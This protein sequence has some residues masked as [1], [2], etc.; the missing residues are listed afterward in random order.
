MRRV[1]TL[2]DD[3]VALIA[4]GEVIER[5]AS[6]VKELIENSLDADAT[7]INIEIVN[8]G[9]DSIIVSDD[10]HG[11]LVEDCPLCIQRHTTSKIEKKSDIETIR[12]YGFR[13]E[14]LSSI[15][16]VAELNIITRAEE[17]ELGCSLSSR[18]GEPPSIRRVSR[19]R[20][21]TVEVRD[22][23]ATVPARRKHLGTPK[24]EAQRIAETVMR[25]AAIREDVGLTLVRDGQT[26]IDCPPKQT[27]L[28]RVVSLWGPAV[29]KMMTEVHHVDHIVGITISGYVV[30]PPLARGNRSREY[31]SVLKR[32]IEDER[33]SRA[34]ETAYETLL[35][36]GQYPMFM[37]DIALNVS[38]VDPNVHPAKREV[39]FDR[40]DEVENILRQAVTI[41][42]RPPRSQDLTASL[43]DFVVQPQI[44]DTSTDMQSE[45]TAP[46]PRDTPRWPLIERVS[47]TSDEHEITGIPENELLGGTFRI[48]GQLNNLYILL[49]F[50]DGLVIIDQ[51]AAHERVM[52]ERL[53]RQISEGEVPVQ[54]LLEPLV[55]RVDPSTLECVMSVS[56][57]LRVLGF[58]IEPF[59]SGEIIISAVPSILG[60]TVTETDLLALFDMIVELG[61]LREGERLMDDLVKITACHSA[62]RAGE[63]LTVHQIRDLLQEMAHTPDRYN[64]PHGR[65]TMIKLTNAELATRFRRT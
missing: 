25:Y 50:D 61:S 39:R 46:P 9:I 56:D 41:A 53:R 8:G 57:E 43:E 37:L 45:T 30:R 36:R 13:G 38:S 18:P 15:A 24:K 31:L 26:I 28:D 60:R 35:M 17:E 51:H 62:I 54:E 16:A 12:T 40:P 58:S 27:R 59:G 1:R 65:P 21:T 55:M 11:I 32:P 2:P 7:R 5:P 29:G 34:V 19:P 48:L 44:L 33:L 23:F 47:L 14:A 52:Y 10:G 20:G 49:E 64:C 63:P 42:L 6:V 3:I 22:L 4:A